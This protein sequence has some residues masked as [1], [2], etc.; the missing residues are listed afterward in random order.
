MLRGKEEHKLSLS[1]SSAPTRTLDSAS[2]VWRRIGL[3]L[4]EANVA[5]SEV[6]RVSSAHQRRNGRVIEVA[7]PSPAEG[8]GVHAGD[9]FVGV[10]DRETLTIDQ[11]ATMLRLPAAVADGRVKF[12]IVREGKLHYGHMDVVS[13]E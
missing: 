6:R 1:L 4:D 2:V 10:H 9:I 11:V 12:W 5:T 3:K 7:K 8:A 13:E